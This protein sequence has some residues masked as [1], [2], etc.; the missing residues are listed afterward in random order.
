MET[1]AGPALRETDPNFAADLIGQ[2]AT[3]MLVCGGDGRMRYAN[4]AALALL[5][6]PA[7]AIGGQPVAALLPKLRGPFCQCLAGRE[8]VSGQE[9]ELAPA[10]RDPVRLGFV[11]TPL[12]GSEPGE[13][14][15]ELYQIAR[16]QAISREAER[17]E[18]MTA[19]RALMQGLA[20]E[21]RNPL[22]G[23][24]GALQV[25]EKDRRRE[26]ALVLARDE[27]ARMRRLLEDLF[28]SRG[29]AVLGPTGVHEPLER[30]VRL[31]AAQL[32]AGVT[33]VRDYDPSLP[34]VAADSDALVQIFLNL[35]RNAVDAVG[36]AGRITLR[37]RVRRQYTLAGQRHR[38]AVCAEI[39]DDGPGVPQELAS[40]LFL[41]LVSGRTD[42]TGLG[43]SVAQDLAVRAGGL[44]D[45]ES[46]PGATTFSLLLPVPEE[47]ARA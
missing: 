25:L 38:L 43:L 47:G 22:T 23:L 2:C 30:A 17:V 37:T 39:I 8:T 28:A 6:I 3:A 5:G 35:L 24:A 9:V 42:G 15:I 19:V 13:V 14:L 4:A 45:Y 1:G 40:T 16:Q 31:C 21:L 18:Q 10:G 7:H 32:P 29:R 11:L 26:D 20:H 41:P 46:Q 34:D 27:V 33:V 44:V 36:G 12:G